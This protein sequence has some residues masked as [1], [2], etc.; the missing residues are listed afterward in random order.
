MNTNNNKP[1]LQKQVCPTC[2]GSFIGRA[3]GFETI[4][5]NMKDSRLDRI[6]S[7]IIENEQNTTRQNSSE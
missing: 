4:L 2:R 5:R 3:F 7:T 1:F 6:A